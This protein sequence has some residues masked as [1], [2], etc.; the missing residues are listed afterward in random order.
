MQVVPLHHRRNLKLMGNGK[1]MT[2]QAFQLRRSSWGVTPIAGAQL[3][4]FASPIGVRA[5]GLLSREQ[6][7]RTVWYG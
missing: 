3:A 6:S 7:T 4:G 1:C 5:N 2:L